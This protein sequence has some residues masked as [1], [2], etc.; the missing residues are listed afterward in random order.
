MAKRDTQPEAMTTELGGADG[1]GGASAPGH[2]A[3]A[4]GSNTAPHLAYHDLRKWI[5][6]AQR[7]GEVKEVK[8]LS[9]Q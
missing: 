4:P 9:W 1:N 3:K 6:E 2:D 5:E 8:G 7:L